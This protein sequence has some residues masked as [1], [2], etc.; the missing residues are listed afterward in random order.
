MAGFCKLTA[1]PVPSHLHT[2]LLL[3]CQH[4]V[5]VHP[6]AEQKPP[7][8]L[9]QRRAEGAGARFKPS[10]TQAGSQAARQPG[11]QCA[12]AH[13]RLVGS[14]NDEPGQSESAQHSLHT[15]SLG[16][17][18]PA[19][20]TGQCLRVAQRVPLLLNGGATPSRHTAIAHTRS[21]MMDSVLP[22]EVNLRAS[23]RE[24]TGGQLSEGGSAQCAPVLA[25]LLHAMPRGP[26]AVWTPLH[27]RDDAGVGPS[28]AE[29]VE[30]RAQGGGG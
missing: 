13:V 24:G 10:F 4:L 28:I 14:S 21:P 7:T 30:Q 18:F 29:P 16:Q 3:P 12:G 20:T 6:F 5:T 23:H 19:T 27:S 25:T 15:P 26:A 8:H 9:L 22:P 1:Q 11:R 2:S 17:T